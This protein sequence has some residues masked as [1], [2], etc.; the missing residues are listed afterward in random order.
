VADPLNREDAIAYIKRKAGG[1]VV[2]LEV[3]EDQIEDRFDDAIRWYISRRGVKRFAVQNIAQGTQ[4]Y[5]MPDDCDEVLNLTFPGVQ[6]D[7][8]AAVNPFAFID[9]DQLPVAYQSI[10]GVPGGA[11]YGTLHQILAHAETARR[12]VGSEPAWEYFKEINTLH[13]FPRT[14]RAGT[15]LARYISTTLNAVDPVSPAIVPVNDFKKL[16]FRD[17][18]IILRYAQ[19]QVEIQ[20]GK[21][22]RKYGEWPGAGGGKTM[23]GDTMVADAMAAIEKMDEEIKALSEPVPFLVG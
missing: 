16:R 17:R 9:V 2:V 22:R 20:I 5:V 14:V 12:I 8:I 1:G 15:A 6:L 21:H 4:E 13:I 7:I 11:F 23:D 18:D 19:A 3:T 10:T